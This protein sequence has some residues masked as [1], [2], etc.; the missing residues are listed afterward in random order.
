[1]KP[2][3]LFI[4]N[5]GRVERIN[6]KQEFAKDFFYGYFNFK[7]S[8]F[9]SNLSEINHKSVFLI[10]KFDKGIN[11]LTKLPIH[12]SSFFNKDLIKKV[13]T[14]NHIYLVNESVMFY[15][16][17]YLVF[18]KRKN[19]STN[20]FIM[21]LFSN[22][23][24]MGKRTVIY[25]FILKNMILP[26]IDNFLFLGRGEYELASTNYQQYKEKFSFTPFGI[27]TYFWK[28]QEQVIPDKKKY[29]LFIG[30]D[31]NRD[32]DFLIKLISEMPEFNFVLITS[33][34]SKKDVDFE[35]VKLSN[36]MWWSNKIS[37]TELKNLYLDASLSIIPLMETFQPS[38][39]SVALQSMATGTPVIITETKG[40]WDPL[41]V[42]NNQ[43][44]IFL[45][46][47]NIQLWANKIREL[48]N[49]ESK[50]KKIAN[51]AQ[52]LVNDKYNLE[53]FSKTIIDNSIN[54]SQSII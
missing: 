37:D 16:L 42:I 45:D 39:Q 5:P 41:N 47:N 15:L 50:L 51:N 35:N 4:F 21:G 23:N 19:T 29:I 2:S 33:R 12:L 26:N 1:M 38:G 48:L 10:S 27:D 28:P 14:N 13:N 25:K 9:K 11:K 49:N 8:G 17:P 46:K 44:I 32:Y 31:L 24:T 30:N 22:I 34:I 54:K 36:G 43:D 7:K 6:Q 52:K 20:V 40:F 18:K 3:I 53:R